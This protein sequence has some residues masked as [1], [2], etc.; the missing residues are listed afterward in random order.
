[1]IAAIFAIGWATQT[2]DAAIFPRLRLMPLEWVAV[3]LSP[4]LVGTLI[5]HLTAQTAV[6][7]EL[8]KLP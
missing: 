3:I 8:A 7:K 5:A 6:M 1:M 4:V 2:I